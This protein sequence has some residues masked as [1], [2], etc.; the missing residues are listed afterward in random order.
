MTERVRLMLATVLVGTLAAGFWYATSTTP[1]SSE[2]AN[3]GQIEAA[4]G[5]VRAWAA[6]ATTRD[7]GRLS[8]WFAT[9][10]PQYSQL[11]TEV[12]DIGPGGSYEFSLS[13]AEVVEP[14]LV[15]GSVTVIGGGGSNQTYRWD[16]ELIKEQGRWLVWTV[17]TSS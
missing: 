13:D 11:E 1:A 6:F 10:G 3:A 17:R 16:I 15:R 12:A 7:I 2:G 9:D 4:A 14:G 8:G 5:A